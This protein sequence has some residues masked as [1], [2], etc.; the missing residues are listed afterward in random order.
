MKYKLSKPV[1]HISRVRWLL[2]FPVF[3][4]SS[5]ITLTILETSDVHGYIYNW[6]YYAGTPY[7]QGLAMVQTVVKEERKK[8]PKLLLLDAGDTIQGTPL[9]YYFNNIAPEYPNPMAVAMNAMQFDAMTI[10]NHDYN[11]GQDVLDKFIREADF[12][13]MSANIRRDDGS[14]KYVPYT[15]KEVKGVKVGILGL[16]TLGIPV[17]ENPDHIRGLRFDGVVETA[18]KYIS[19][20]EQEGAE[21]ILAL[22]HSGA[23][24]EPENSRDPEAWLEPVESWVDKGY[25]HVPEQNFVIVL[26][27]AVPEIDV[28]FSGHAHSVNPQAFINGVLV[29]EPGFWGRGVSKVTL[30]VSEDGQIL[31]KEGEYFSV[32]GRTP[33]PELLDITRFY[34]ETTLDYVN[35]PIGNATGD[36]PGGDAAR[37]KDGPLADLINTIQ[38]KMAADAGYPVDISLAAIFNNRGHLEKGPVTIADIYGIYQYDN[39]LYVMEITGD[40]LKRALE[41]DASYWKHVDKD[42]L[43]A[44]T[45]EDLK[46]GNTRDYNW[47]MYTG[48]EYTID[49]TQPAGERVITLKYKGNNISPDQKLILAINN[50]RAGGGGGYTMFKEGKILWQSMSVIRDYMVDYIQERKIL[51]PAEIYHENWK[52]LPESAG[53]LAN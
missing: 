12:P 45:I 23:H 29:V 50:Y 18:K 16:T 21:V 52:L 7:E 37:I 3:L 32:A 40:I 27:E 35:S 51:D 47:D 6:D 24:V 11:F 13:V 17:W 5:D 36:F 49:L 9:M 15:I 43:A 1:L 39:T 25:A 20:M 38:L 28:I 53:S 46:S 44:M 19:R 34:Q 48:V 33:D 2:L 30:T 8:D 42:G 22:V 4:L 14:E 41:H 10:G 26:A 31:S